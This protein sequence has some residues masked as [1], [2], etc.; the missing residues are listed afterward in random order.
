MS[1]Q[2]TGRKSHRKRNGAP[3]VA[4][5]DKS[6][7]KDERNA[8]TKKLER[9]ASISSE[10]EGKERSSEEGQKGRESEAA[11]TSSGKPGLEE[12]GGVPHGVSSLTGTPLAPGASPIPTPDQNANQNLA[13]S[14]SRLDPTPQNPV[15]PTSVLPPSTAANGILSSQP[16]STLS[17]NQAAPEQPSSL[18]S[19][20]SFSGSSL[21]PPT[22]Y[23]PGSS[24]TPSNPSNLANPANPANPANAANLASAYAPSTTAPPLSSA[25]GSSY[26]RSGV[27]A[28][29][30]PPQLP[31]GSYV[32]GASAG[33]TSPAS[34]YVPGASAG[35]LGQ[36]S[37]AGQSAGT[38]LQRGGPT[39]AGPA[40]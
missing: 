14:S 27:D 30:R 3:S 11:G 1:I 33:L 22:T 26:G 36:S 15:G 17:S 24:Y 40:R 20:P 16:G 25:L 28:S 32:P 34:A 23:T 12:I 31:T 6:A 29:A 9:S 4:T 10:Q 8:S 2:P 35:R 5:A 37:A 21:R 7:S 19:R 38:G 39:S 13:P 18:A